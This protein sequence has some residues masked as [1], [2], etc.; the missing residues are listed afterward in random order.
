[1]HI[2]GGNVQCSFVCVLQVATVLANMA[3]KEEYRQDLCSGGGLVVL[4]CFLQLRP[5]MGHTPPQLAACER[6]QQKAAIA[7]ARLC[8]NAETSNIVADMQGRKEGFTCFRY[9]DPVP[10]SGAKGAVALDPRV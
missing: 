10:L 1:M 5:S 6:I 3:A 8:T 2:I 9:T 7:L 4:L